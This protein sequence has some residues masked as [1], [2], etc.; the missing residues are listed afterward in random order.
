MEQFEFHP[1]A[2]DPGTGE[3]RR[4]V[5]LEPGIEQM[6]LNEDAATGRRT[7]LQRWRA[8]AA[9]AQQNFVHDYVEEIFI[10]EGDLEDTRRGGRW[11]AGAYAY[12]KPGMDHGPFCSEKGCLMFIVIVPDVE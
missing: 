1:Y 4:W 6:T 11:E 9:N 3:H 7:V 8:G 10:V 5:E 12:R 2:R